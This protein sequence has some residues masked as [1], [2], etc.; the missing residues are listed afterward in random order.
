[1][2]ED[3]GLLDIEV[4]YARPD[5]Q[6]VLKLRM[7]PDTTLLE[8]VDRSGLLQQCPEID[9]QVMKLGVFGVVCSPDRLVK[10][11]DRVEV[12]RPLRHDPK[13]A[14]RLRANKI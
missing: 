9:W 2:D 11:A 5:R 4:A 12:Y 6:F 1:M 14:R 10:Q 13:Q 8:A 3:A 7:P